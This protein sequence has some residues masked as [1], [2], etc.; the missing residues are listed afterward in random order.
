MSCAAGRPPKGHSHHLLLLHTQGSL[1][2]QDSPWA[3]LVKTADGFLIS[4]S[5]SPSGQAPTP[6]IKAAWVSEIRKVLTSQLQACR[7]EATFDVC[8][9]SHVPLSTAQEPLACEG[10]MLG[11]HCV[12]LAPPQQRPASTEP[13]SSPTAFLCPRHPALG[14]LA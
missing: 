2:S 5:L 8:V 12:S 1:G 11:S 4:G 6:E 10:A 9:F 13:W 14:E 7:G 3:C